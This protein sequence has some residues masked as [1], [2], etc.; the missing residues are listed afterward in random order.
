MAN[1]QTL[2][3]AALIERLGRLFATDAHTEGL[4]PVHWEAMRYLNK[5][6][7]FSRTHA[8]LTAY[9]GLTKGTVSQTLK[10][11]EG[12]G[13]VRKEA[14]QQDRRS[15]RLR[16]TPRGRNLL[17]RDPAGEWIDQLNHLPAAN[18]KDLARGLSALVSARLSAQGRAPFGQCQTCMYFLAEHAEGNPHYCDLLKT[19]LTP[20]G[21]ALIC[22][23]QQSVAGG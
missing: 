13:L 4:L 1:N 22:V 10:A 17:K 16:L 8:A 18:R 14:D 3:I 23:E 9:L 12:K 5:A 6:N 2:E 21:A 11:L 19:E 7:Q 15:K 20:D